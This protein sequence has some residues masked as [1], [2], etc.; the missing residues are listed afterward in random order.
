MFYI[1]AAQLK[2]KSEDV[3][4]KHIR[5]AKEFN[6]RRHHEQSE[7]YKYQVNKEQFKVGSIDQL[8]MLNE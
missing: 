5:E 1:V 4:E 8:M 6:D 3:V 2:D 7:L